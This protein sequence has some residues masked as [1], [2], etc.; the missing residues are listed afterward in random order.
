ML[1]EQAHS[2]AFLSLITVLPEGE[3]RHPYTTRSGLAHRAT[4]HLLGY[5]AEQVDEIELN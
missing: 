4:R 2:Q 5:L 3:V 1:R